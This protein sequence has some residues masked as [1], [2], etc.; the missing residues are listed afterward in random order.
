MSEN[1][2]ECALAVEVEWAIHG[3]V[4]GKAVAGQWVTDGEI[5]AGATMPIAALAC[6]VYANRSDAA[7][8]FRRIADWIDSGEGAEL[9]PDVA[10]RLS[11]ARAGRVCPKPAGLAL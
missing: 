5:M 11:Q 2:I 4:A 1:D 6:A 8:L 10:W 3:L 9:A 7:D